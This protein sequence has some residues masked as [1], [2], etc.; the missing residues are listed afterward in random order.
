MHQGLVI[1]PITP[2]PLV[3]GRNVGRV[4]KLIS[5]VEGLVKLGNGRIEGCQ[6]PEVIGRTPPCSSRA[7]GGVVGREQADQPRSLEASTRQGRPRPSEPFRGVE[8][9]QQAGALRQD[10]GVVREDVG[11]PIPGQGGE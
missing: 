1:P 5:N 2:H 11:R 8:R 7:N 4:G 10:L 3:E 9:R 6:G